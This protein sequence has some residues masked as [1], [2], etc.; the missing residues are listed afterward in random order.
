VRLIIRHMA[1]AVNG[2]PRPDVWPSLFSRA[3]IAAYVSP[4]S[5]IIRA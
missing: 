3:A 1:I 4:V 2:L 5:R